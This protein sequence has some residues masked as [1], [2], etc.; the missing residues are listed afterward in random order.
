M[1]R[2]C[3]I[4]NAVIG[5]FLE[6]KIRYR[7]LFRHDIPACKNTSQPKLAYARSVPSCRSLSFLGDLA[8]GREVG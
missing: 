1:V 5:L 6:G 3:R 4:E 2:Q 8:G 7:W